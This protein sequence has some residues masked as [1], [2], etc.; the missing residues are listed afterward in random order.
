MY[1]WTHKNVSAATATVML[2]KLTCDA[3]STAGSHVAEI[4][5]HISPTLK[6]CALRTVAIGTRMTVVQ[7]KKKGQ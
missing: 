3:E 4:K 6:A 7:G 1:A 5:E 2:Q